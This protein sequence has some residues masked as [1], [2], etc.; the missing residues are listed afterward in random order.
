[1]NG[2]HHQFSLLAMEQMTLLSLIFLESKGGFDYAYK[3]QAS[4]SGGPTK[5]PAPTETPLLKQLFTEGPWIF[6]N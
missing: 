1:M 2:N 6:Y 4:A 5:R 3:E